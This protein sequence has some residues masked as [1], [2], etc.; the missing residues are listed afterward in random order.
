[1]HCHS[2]HIKWGAAIVVI[3]LNYAYSCL[4]CHFVETH[5]VICTDAMAEAVAENVEG[6]EPPVECFLAV[7]CPLEKLPKLFIEC[8]SLATT[9]LSGSPR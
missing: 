8:S 7:L 4:H 1:M 3:I 5:P 2:S 6:L 9:I